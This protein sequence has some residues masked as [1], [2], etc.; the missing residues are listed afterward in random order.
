MSDKVKHLGTGTDLYT[1]EEQS[2]ALRPSP[3]AAAHLK[4]SA[5]SADARVEHAAWDAEF[6]TQGITEQKEPLT[7]SSGCGSG[8]GDSDLNSKLRS[9]CPP[10]SS[11]TSAWP[12][13]IFASYLC[14]IVT[15]PILGKV[16]GWS[17]NPRSRCWHN[18]A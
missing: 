15:P 10:G 12:V 17:E 8:R 16:E 2:D 9:S 14:H 1:L 5:P 6:R 3:G 7:Q 18:A 11:I 4:T 13:A